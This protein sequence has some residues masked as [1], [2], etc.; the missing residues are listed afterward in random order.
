VNAEPLRIAAVSAHS[1]L[2]EDSPQDLRAELLEMTGQ[3]FRRINRFIELAVYGALRCGREAG[4]V[5]GDTA[6]YLASEAPML[7]DCVRALRGVIAE[8]RPP[9]PFEFMNISGNMAGFY[10]A[11]HLRMRG[12]QLAVHRNS[13][14]LE[15]ALDLLQLQSAR[16][17]RALLG[18]VEEGVWPLTEQRLRL[19][20]PATAELSESSHW[21]YLD[22][23]CAAP[24]GLIDAIERCSTLAQAQRALAD[25][26][27]QWRVSIGHRCSEADVDALRAARPD[28]QMMETDGAY[29]TATTA[30]RLI[31]F[32][33]RDSAPG[34]LQVN[35][36]GDGGY[37]LLRTRRA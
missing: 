33:L 12:P 7:A 15:C 19:G 17:R 37:Y 13:A 14:S 2:L 8:A 27:A 6:L 25:A 10:I 26:P 31:G 3:A 32:L 16:H 5:G 9:T 20:L 29:S 36:S 23:D 35:H 11:Q 34:L 30:M 24:L 18:Y 22:A 21:F 28:A 4:G 1:R